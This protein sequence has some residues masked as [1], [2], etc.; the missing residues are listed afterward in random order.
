MH[1]LLRCLEA[2]ASPAHQHGHIRALP[3]TISMQLVQHNETQSARALNQLLFARPRHQQLQ[4]DIIRQQDIRRPRQDA[5][6]FFTRFLPRIAGVA[7]RLPV[8]RKA[9]A[10]ILIQL[11]YLAVDQGVHGINDDRLDALAAATAQDMIDDG[12]DVGQTRAG[13][14]ARGQSVM[15]AAAGDLNGVALMP[16]QCHGG[17]ALPIVRREDGY[18][19][20]LKLPAAW[21]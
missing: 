15:M 4:H 19:A 21:Q 18:A 6:A 1:L 17:A 12:R 5:L 10:Q 7:D 16:A 8:F 2:I 13:A 14:S 9:F 11:F 20:L 3:S